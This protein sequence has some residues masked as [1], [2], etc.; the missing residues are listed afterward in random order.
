VHSNLSWMRQLS[1][2]VC[3]AGGLR[4]GTLCWSKVQ[5]YPYHSVY[6]FVFTPRMI[7]ASAPLEVSFSSAMLD[8]SHYGP[9]SMSAL[10]EKAKVAV[11]GDTLSL[12]DVRVYSW[13]PFVVVYKTNDRLDFMTPKG[14]VSEC[15][16]R[17]AGQIRSPDNFR[18]L[19]AWAK[20]KA[21]NYNIP[22]HLLSTCLFAACNLAFIQDLSSET[23]IM[24]AL[25]KPN[26]SLIEAHESALNRKFKWVWTAPEVAAALTTLG[27]STAG[28]GTAAHL[29][30]AA[31]GTVTGLGLAAAGLAVTVAGIAASKF[32]RSADP[33]AG[34]RANRTSNGPR[35]AVI[36]LNR[37]TQLPASEP[38]KSIDV[39][40]D[41]V[42][43]PLD[44]TAKLEVRDPLATREV[45]DAP[46]VRPGH[47]SAAAALSA[48]M[49]N[50]GRRLP[51]PPASKVMPL[52]AAGIVTDFSI[53][54]VPANS[55]HSALSAIVERILK[56]GPMGRGEVDLD[57]FALFR[58]WVFTNLP[59]LGLIPESVQ[60]MSFDDWNS[61]YAEAQRK[62]HTLALRSVLVDDNFLPERVHMRGMFTKI[63]SL[64]KSSLDGIAKLAPRGI[65]SGSAVHNVVTGRFCKSFSKHLKE[66]WSVKSARGLMYTSGASAEEIGAA[67]TAALESCPGF[68]ILEGD[69]ARFD[70]TIHR[71]F[72][73]L[74]ADIYRWSGCS[75]REYAAFL[76]CILTKGQD[77]WKTKYEVD[78]GRHSGDH[79]TS[80]GNSLLQGLAIM[81]CL[82]FQHARMH[83]EL[84]SYKR[85]VELYNVA[86]L[87][88]GDDNLLVADAAFLASLGVEVKELVSLLKMLGLE[89]EPKLH[90]GPHAKYH[91][92][93]CSAR[94]YPVAGGKTVLAPGVGR[95]LAKSAWYVDTPPAMSVERMLRGDAIGKMKDCWFVPFLGPMWRRNLA[96]TKPFAG[97]EIMTKELRRTRLHNAHAAECHEPSAETYEMVEILYGL[98]R[99]DEVLYESMLASVKSLPCIVTLDKFYHAMVVDGVAED[100]HDQ[101]SGQSMDEEKYP[102]PILADIAATTSSLSSSMQEHP[103]AMFASGAHLSVM[104]ACDEGSHAAVSSVWDN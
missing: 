27:V 55:A 15:A 83:G 40:L 23:A 29:L 101:V 61:S 88:L 21:S 70:S 77:K 7:E 84:P 69:F 89:L 13:G 45:T 48:Q 33:F 67:F 3:S 37:G 76:S 11:G 91:A 42:A 19:V 34:Y 59:E 104:G 85:L 73:E 74:E 80:C 44:P 90:V 36:P 56:R 12:P 28:L 50:E 81:F 1:A 5:S 68:S 30:G 31:V 49:E 9:V 95:G 16:V 65:Q 78:G 41:P 60:R 102:T 99:D 20:F 38:A 57:L 39:L 32:S 22:P 82:A 51:A 26:R 86:M 62:Q 64:P 94:F 4:L 10:N 52:V 58:K 25:I 72:L 66:K 35:T 6:A 75:E 46:A 63:E 43:T 92:S 96:L 97:K 79:N 98:T 87:V 54:V 47:A 17:C 103:H 71:L 53:P 100:V 93:F 14:L 8:P 2:P 24:H 18:N